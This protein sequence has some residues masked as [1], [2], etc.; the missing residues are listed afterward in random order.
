MNIRKPDSCSIVLLTNCMF[1]CKMC[2]MWKSKD[3][4]YQTS[5]EEWKCFIDSLDNLLA[6]P[7]ELVFSGGEP[8]LRKDI[9]ELIRLGADR[10]FKTLMTSNGYLIDEDMAK[11]INNSGLKEIFISLDSHNEKTH[12][13]LRGV[14]GSHKKTM[15]AFDNL[16][17]H[18]PDLNIGIITVISGVNYDE[19]IDLIKWVK[20]LGF[21][22]GV[23]FQVIAKPFF[24]AIDY[25]WKKEKSYE[26]LWPK[27]VDRVRSMLDELVSFKKDGYPI[28]NF[29]LHIE[30]FK[31]YFQ[32]PFKRATKARCGLGSRVI[33]INPAGDASL[34]CF[35][36][37]IGNIKEHSIEKLW[38]SEKTSHLRQRM[39][40]CEQNCNNFINCFFKEENEAS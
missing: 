27:E 4:P 32:D 22:S 16:R 2:E 5:T 21:L 39:L 15:E 20:K 18:C 28:H 7:R 26:F 37:P 34:C 36:E 13:F 19:I 14:D 1:K 31:S 9:F 17:R 30:V 25:D 33:N 8:L 23:Y 11:K 35:M 10:G 6:G 38:F 3:D 40:A 29:P 12:N 24:A